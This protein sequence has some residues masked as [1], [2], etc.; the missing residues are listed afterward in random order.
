MKICSLNQPMP[1]GGIAWRHPFSVRPP[2]R[3]RPLVKVEV[4]RVELTEAAK[5]ITLTGEIRA[6]VESDLGFRTSGRITE[7]LVGVGDHVSSGQILAKL[8]PQEQQAR[9]RQR[10]PRFAPRR[11]NCAMRPLIWTGRN[12]CFL[13]NRPHNRSMIARRNR[14]APR[15]A[16]SR[17]QKLSLGQRETL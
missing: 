16:R 2:G 12:F 10:K 9:S 6:Q 4:Q 3:P 1:A 17:P 14:S 15:K 11:Q 7:R 5:T 13:A 8:D